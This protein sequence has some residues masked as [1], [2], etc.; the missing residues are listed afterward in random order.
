MLDILNDS[1][2]SPDSDHMIVSTVIRAHHLAAGAK[3]GFTSKVHLVSNASGLPIRAEITG[4][5]ASNYEGYDLLYDEDQKPAKVLITDR[6]YDSDHI[7]ENI[8]QKDGATVIPT[9]KNRKARVLVDRFIY[10]LR[11]Q[12]ERCFHKMKNSRRFATK[13]DKFIPILLRSQQAVR[14]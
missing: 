14:L 3:G 6:G 9:R 8:A 5:E 2:L 11:N 10:A 7:R 4:G 1:D 12:V 13:C